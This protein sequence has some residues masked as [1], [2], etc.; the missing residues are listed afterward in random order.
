L[1][2]FLEIASYVFSADCA[3]PRGKTWSDEESRE[4]WERDLAFVIAVREPTFW[5][6]AEITGLLQEL[7]NFLSNDKF[8]FTFVP[9]ERDRA[10]QQTY[11]QFGGL[12]SWPFHGP[13]RVLMFSGGLDSLSGAVETA[14]RGGR[15]VLVSHRPVSTLDARQKRLFREMQELFP[16]QLIRVPVWINKAESFG[17]EPTQRTRSFLYAALGTLVAQS[18]EAGGVRFYENGIVSLNLP[19]AQEVLRAR[20][21]RTTH[22]LALHLLSNLCAAVTERDFAVDN[23]Y[24]FKTKTEVVTALTTHQA[25]NLVGYT[26]SCA[27]SIFKSKVQR[28]CGRCSQCIDRRFAITAAGLLDYDSKADYVS[29]VFLGPCKDNLERAMAADYARHG[30]ELARR[31]E[32]ELA[33]FFNTE[34]S[35]AVRHEPRRNEAAQQIISM[36]KRHGDV[37]SRVLEEKLHENASRLVTGTVDSTSLLAMVVAQ[38][39]LQKQHAFVANRADLAAGTAAQMQQMGAQGEARAHSSLEY[40]PAIQALS[41]AP[42]IAQVSLADL[43][44]PVGTSLKETKRALLKLGAPSRRLKDSRILE[45]ADYKLNNPKC[46]YKEVSI[47]FF[48]TPRRADSIRSWVNKRKS[49]GK[50]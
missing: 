1:V 40:P 36:H 26:C 35:R 30:I 47:K 18:V 11:F 16:D 21:S 23:P 10:N 3:T 32:S 8:F 24:L 41:V 20:A 43:N 49:D 31:S 5:G 29:D 50:Q 22:P 33:A 28:H 27:H 15:L 44:V 42:G 25:A 17:R 39:H 9:L 48:G 2:D 6:T 4:P 19:V 46:G 12:K 37:V 34:L 38:Q 45:A 14:A 7:L 13:D